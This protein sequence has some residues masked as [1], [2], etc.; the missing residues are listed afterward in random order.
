MLRPRPTGNKSR[1]RFVGREHRKTCTG[2]S[3]GH[4]QEGA[5][6][7]GRAKRRARPDGP[8]GGLKYRVRAGMGWGDRPDA[9]GV[10]LAG[11]LPMRSRGPSLAL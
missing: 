11:P 6:G 8:R 5:V 10:L 1:R 4:G 9:K 3:V 2:C 7:V